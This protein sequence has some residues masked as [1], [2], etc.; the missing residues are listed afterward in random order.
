MEN[1]KLNSDNQQY[2]DDKSEVQSKING[3]Y[4]IKLRRK[5]SNQRI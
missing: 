1:L 2:T 4:L 5:K 3:S